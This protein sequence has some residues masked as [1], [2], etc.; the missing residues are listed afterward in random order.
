MKKA[1]PWILGII[2]VL[3]G[4]NHLIHPEIYIEMIPPFIA[5]NIANIGAGVVEILIGV[6]FF[7][8]TFR[9]LGGLAFAGLM[10]AFLP[11]HIWDVFREDP[12]T[13]N[14]IIAIMRLGLQV[15]LVYAGWWVYKNER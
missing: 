2:M 12:V 5:N 3:G 4:I 15:L 9:K 13:G 1:L 6:L 7:I 11:L 14:K 10:L 8:P